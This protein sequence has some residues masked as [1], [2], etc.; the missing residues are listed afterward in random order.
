MANWRIIGL[1]G[2]GGVAAAGVLLSRKRRAWTEPSPE[3]LRDKLHDRLASGS[4]LRPGDGEGVETPAEPE[5]ES[6]AGT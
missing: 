3:E 5:P 1:A 2:I 6:G 4:V